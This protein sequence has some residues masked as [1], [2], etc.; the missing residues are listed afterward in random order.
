MDSVFNTV[1]LTTIVI[2][3]KGLYLAPR[4]YVHQNSS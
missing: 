4:P 2:S 3:V 1:H